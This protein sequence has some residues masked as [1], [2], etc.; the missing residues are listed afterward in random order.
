MSTTKVQGDMIDVDAATVAVVAAGDKFNFLDITDS[1]VKEDTVQGILDLAAG[2]AW[3]LIT[4][5]TISDDATISFTGFDDSTY[6]SYRFWLENVVPATDG[7]KLWF[8]TSTDG[9][10]S[11]DSGASD[12]DW[13]VSHYRAD[14][15]TAFAYYDDNDAQIKLAGEGAGSYRIDNTAGNGGVNG[16]IEIFDPG[17]TASMTF[18]TYQITWA[19]QNGLYPCAYSGHGRRNSAADVDA[20]Q[21]LADSGNLTSGRI[22]FEGLK[23]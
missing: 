20:V 23:K 3:T 15:T 12:Y 16:T 21:F 11:Y 5:T 22:L 1:L 17:N 13:S 14:S 18:V 8:R 2:G 4:A 7:A 10:S 6:S 9:G 19:E